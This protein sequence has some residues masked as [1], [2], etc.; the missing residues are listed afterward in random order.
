MSIEFTIIIA[1]CGHPDRLFRVLRHLDEAI[2]IAGRRHRVIVAD[3]SLGHALAGPVARAAATL[4]LEVRHVGTTPFNKCA[5]LNAGIAAADT[6]WLAFTD[7]DTLPDVRWLLEAGRFAA[8]GVCRV[9]G[10]WIRPCYAEDLVRGGESVSREDAKF[11]KEERERGDIMSRKAL[12]GWLVPGRSGRIPLI[13]GAVVQYEPMTSSG[14]LGPQDP[15][16]LG[17]NIFI[18]RGVFGDHG[19]YDEALWVAC[20]RAAL[21]ADDG[22]FGIRLKA[23]G[24]RIGFCREAIMH[25]PVY[26]ARCT[27]LSHIRSAFRYGWRDPF[28]FFDPQRPVMEWYRLRLLAGSLMSATGRLLTLD[29]G[30]AATDFLDVVKLC[31]SMAGRG[32]QSYRKWE[33]RGNENRQDAP[34]A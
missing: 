6:E 18:R 10:G 3:N 32:S 16:P 2:R 24:E 22:E 1:T 8:S 14:L 34:Y 33:R 9:F 15:I 31:G 11:A 25:H 7:D 19:G 20:G 23:R 27:F 21:G 30:A 5:A 17:A 12:P 4:S 29:C 13:S 28:V 26:A